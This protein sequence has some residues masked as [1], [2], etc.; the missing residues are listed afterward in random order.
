[1][2]TPITPFSRILLL[3]APLAV[4]LALTSA[5]LE[6]AQAD[7]DEQQV[8]RFDPVAQQFIATP[9]EEQRTGY[10]Y[11]R[12]S[13][14]LSRWV[15]SL[16]E[17]DG[18]FS[19]AL[20]EGTTQPAQRLDQKL[21]VGAAKQ[22]LRRI[23][24]T[25]ADAIKDRAGR[26]FVRLDSQDQWELFGPFGVANAFD[27]E[28]GRRWESHGGQYLPVSHTTGYRWRVENGRYVP[29]SAYYSSASHS[30][31]SDCGCGHGGGY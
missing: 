3:V 30:S 2:N 9:A 15:W 26:V 27:M 7:L 8:Y 23:N 12:F 10:V 25:L 5:R 29:A 19:F 13:S 24:P 18:E 1:M 17:G 28:T 31:G 22:A 14:R 6:G 4:C 20:G 11:R 21:T 16:Y